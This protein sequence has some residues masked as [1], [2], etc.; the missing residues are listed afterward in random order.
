MAWADT[1]QLVVVGDQSS[2]KSSVLQAITKLPFPVSE[3]MCT[4]FATEVS[5]IRSSKPAYMS[6]SIQVGKDH[7]TKTTDEHRKEMDD[8]KPALT[9]LDDLNE[10]TFATEFGRLLKEVICFRSPSQI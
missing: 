1:S 6:I 4:R 9:T 2:G 7:A 3:S 10:A 5:L 8:W